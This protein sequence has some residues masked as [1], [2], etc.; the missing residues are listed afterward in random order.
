MKK[1][2]LLIV[3]FCSLTVAVAGCGNPHQPTS[4]ET[5]AITRGNL[6]VSIPASGNM[7]A[8]NKKSVGFQTTGTIQEVK[9]QK[10][11]EVVEGQAL[12]T[13]DSRTL[14]KTIELRR[15]DC[16]DARKAY[17]SAAVSLTK[18]E[19]YRD[20]LDGRAMASDIDKDNAQYAVDSAKLALERAALQIERAQK[21]LDIAI[22]EQEK[23]IITAPFDGV[24]ADISI[25]KGDQ[26]LSPAEQ[27]M[28]IIDLDKLEMNGIVDEIDI[29]RVIPGQQV[30]I[31]L[32]ALS[33]REIKGRVS[34]ISM[35]GTIRA[36]VV[37]YEIV[38]AVEGTDRAIKDGMSTSAE[39]IIEQYEDILLIPNRAIRGSLDSPWVEIIT[40]DGTVEQRQITTGVSDGSSTEIISGLKEGDEVVLPTSTQTLSSLLGL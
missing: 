17:A 33:D 27:A 25:E 4:L 11:D 26:V 3:L 31:V 32:D 18:A 36:G 38:V 21:N 12:A 2:L 35:T 28:L 23:T 8:V 30:V 6:V 34:S 29:S 5:V 39:I 13:L 16:D 10:G 40:A 1:H 9:V 20:Y 14:E 7:E 19:N 24:I 22:L 37:S 15:I